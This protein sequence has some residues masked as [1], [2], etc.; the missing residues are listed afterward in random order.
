MLGLIVDQ[1]M[2]DAADDKLLECV[3]AFV[4]ARGGVPESVGGVELVLVSARRFAV[5]VHCEGFA[6]PLPGAPADG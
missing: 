3:R 2:L 4:E 6:P 5:L 1:T